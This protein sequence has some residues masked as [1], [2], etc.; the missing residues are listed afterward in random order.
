[1]KYTRRRR[2]LRPRP[3]RAQI[4]QQIQRVSFILQFFR[5]EWLLETNQPE[6]DQ[7]RVSFLNDGIMKLRDE[8]ASLEEL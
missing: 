5:L 8:I 7:Q 3:T 1:M 2:H 6:P 4:A